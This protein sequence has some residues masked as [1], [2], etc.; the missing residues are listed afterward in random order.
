MKKIMVIGGS[1][2]LGKAISD[3]LAEKNNKVIIYDLTEPEKLYKNQCYIYGDIM[4]YKN[5]MKNMK[6]VDYVYNFA[7]VSNIEYAHFHPVETIKINVIGNTYV[8]DLCVKNKVKRYVFASSIYVYADK[9]SFYRVSK[10]S[11]E[12]LIEAYSEVY[13]LPYT[14]LRFGSIYGPVDGRNNWLYKII[15]EALKKGVITRLGDGEELREYI[16]LYDAALASVE[17]L[18]KKYEN[19]NVLITGNQKMKIKDILNM[20]NEMMGNK[21]KIIYKP[22]KD[23]LHYEITPFVFKPKLAERL[24]VS[25]HI[26]LGEGILDCAYKIY[27]QLRTASEKK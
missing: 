7:A 1:G 12:L 5:L 26:D 4:D 24:L 23:K 21:I 19:K 18:S 2:F 27:S 11:C 9:G 14:I 25:S 8:L 20:I 3:V 22:I 15:K 13:N 16:H 10:Q 6:G 17:I